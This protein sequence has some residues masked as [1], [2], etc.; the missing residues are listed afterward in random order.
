MS[1]RAIKISTRGS[2]L[3]LW[4]ANHVRD[5]ILTEQPDWQVELVI[6]KTQGDKIL[7]KP[8]AKIGGKALF[9]KEIEQALIDG[10]ADIAVHS[11]KDVPAELAPGLFMAAVSTRENPH[12]AL[13]SA[14]DKRL[15]DLPEGARVGTSSMRRQ[16]Q[17]LATR[18]DL[19]IGMLR[20]N[21]PTRVR[22]LDEG[23]FD[24]IVLAA[25]GLRR[26]GMGE[27]I[28]EELAPD[29]CLPAVGQGVLGIET[30]I[31]DQALIDVVRAA[32]H[33]AREELRV[34]AE[35][36]F[37]LHLGGSCQTPLAAHAVHRD[38][39]LVVDGLCG[40]PDGTRILRAQRVAVVADADAAADLGR[41]V[42]DDLRAQGAQAIIDACTE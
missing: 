6:I 28:S 29:V 13:C 2:K 42:A 25:A 8:L 34:S 22:K 31:D 11:M 24:A 18:P 36:A 1:A 23:Q 12:D 15:S 4:Q 41:A 3:A 19:Q 16:C 37:L 39:Q 21:V 5:T 10:A 27:R 17:L 9:V 38:G 40:M 20:G 33:D 26:L 7:D 32:L 30:R 35:R 14:G